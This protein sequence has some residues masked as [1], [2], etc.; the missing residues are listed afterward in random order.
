MKNTRAIGWLGAT[1][2]LF[3]CS[4]GV[5]P[6]PLDGG[7]GTG[8]GAG[9]TTGGGGVT[10]SGGTGTSGST[11]FDASFD[12]SLNDMR[13]DGVCSA[14]MT[15]A[16]PVPLD[17]YVLMDASLSMNET[18]ST[19]T[20]WADVRNAMKS[21][22]ESQSSA[23]L[24][25]GLKFFPGI[26]SGAPATCTGDGPDT[27]CN[28]FGDCDRRKTCVGANGSTPNVS[29]L[30][31]AA[32]N[33]PTN[34]ACALIKDCGAGSY[35]ASA[36]TGTCAAACMTFAGYCHLRDQLLWQVNPNPFFYGCQFL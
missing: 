28:G 35:C 25:V 22:F 29:P 2:L 4:A 33:C 30:C 10:G 12:I 9:G 34:Q 36:G 6:T 27:A 5:K 16:E 14:T 21:F 17:L 18:T 26:Q 24:G 11:G 19:G 31:V 7:G 15:A 23:G 3:G 13:A 20:K 32:T 8:P 1:A